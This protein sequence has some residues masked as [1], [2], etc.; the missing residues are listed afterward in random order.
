MVVGAQELYK[1]TDCHKI[2]LCHQRKILKWKQDDIVTALDKESGIIYVRWMDNRA[3]AVASTC[4]GVPPIRPV[5]RFS[6]KDK[7]SV[8]VPRPDL[9]C[10]I[11]KYG[12]D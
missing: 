5:D 2:I 12:K 1:K 4:F 10:N 7:K 8:A 6:R 11:I 3:V 9:D